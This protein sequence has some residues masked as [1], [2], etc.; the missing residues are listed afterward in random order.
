MDE[1]VWDIARAYWRFHK[2]EI[3]E[4][5]PAAVQLNQ[6]VGDFVTR[7]HT[8]QDVLNLLDTVEACREEQE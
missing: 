2:E 5:D 4:G 1:L 3:L 8:V 7:T 6:L